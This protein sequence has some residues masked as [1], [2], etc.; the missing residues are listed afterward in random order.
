MQNLKEII[1]SRITLLGNIKGSS[2]G[3]KKTDI[4]WKLEYT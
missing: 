3:K 4:K 1:T 2:S